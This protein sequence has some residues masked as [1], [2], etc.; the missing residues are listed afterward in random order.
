MRKQKWEIPILSIIFVFFLAS[1]WFPTINFCLKGVVKNYVYSCKSL[2]NITWLFLYSLLQ[3]FD[4]FSI[5][6]LP[7]TISTFL[8][9]FSRLKQTKTEQTNLK[10]CSVSRIQN[11]LVVYNYW[12]YQNTL[13]NHLSLILASYYAQYTI[14][15]LN[16]GLFCEETEWL[17]P[18]NSLLFYGFQV[19]FVQIFFSVWVKKR[20]SFCLV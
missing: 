4:F 16:K 6:L 15:N 7:M 11:F 17:L 20:N 1:I 3:H 18:W 10:D 12:L 8:K 9:R 2:Q 19:L 5:F 13:E 14:R